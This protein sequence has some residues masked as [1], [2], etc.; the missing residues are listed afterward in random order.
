VLMI[1]SSIN[2]FSNP[3][4]NGPSALDEDRSAENDRSSTGVNGG[5]YSGTR[6]GLDF[7]LI[8]VASSDKNHQQQQQQLENLADT[9]DDE[10]EGK[11]MD[12]EKATGG[13]SDMDVDTA[14]VESTSTMD[15]LESE[16]AEDEAGDILVGTEGEGGMELDQA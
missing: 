13:G 2:E 1:T 14:A 3:A 16:G 9:K 5:D 4:Y 12:V 11:G 10:N 6:S 15:G 7:G 8:T